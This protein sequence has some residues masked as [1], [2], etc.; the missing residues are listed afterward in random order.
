MEKRRT[1]IKIIWIKP[2]KKLSILYLKIYC[3][4]F[5]AYSNS[6]KEY[7]SSIWIKKFI[8]FYIRVRSCSNLHHS[9]YHIL[10]FDFKWTSSRSSPQ[11]SP[12]PIHLSSPSAKPKKTGHSSGRT[13]SISYKPP[14]E[15]SNQREMTT[16]D[17]SSKPHHKLGSW[18]HSSTSVPKHPLST[19][20]RTHQ[21]KS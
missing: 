4:C 2:C 3:L 19:T 8:I 10:K 16:G 18:P 11:I 6:K 7:F 12:A 13:P 15:P 14:P 21:Y 9:N 5:K 17:K 20:D 1:W